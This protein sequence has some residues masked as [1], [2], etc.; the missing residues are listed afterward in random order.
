MIKKK[1]Q[2][3]VRNHLNGVRSVQTEA[4]PPPLPRPINK[5]KPNK[6]YPPLTLP[7]KKPPTKQTNKQNTPTRT[8][9][10]KTKQPNTKEHHHQ[11]PLCPVEIQGCGLNPCPCVLWS[12]PPLRVSCG[13]TPSPCVLWLW[14]DPLSVCPVWSDPLSVCPVA[15]V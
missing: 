15:V 12:D 13:L 6:K 8:T 11:R 14:S 9:I 7:P 4:A 2:R 1:T 3:F 10:T 5:R